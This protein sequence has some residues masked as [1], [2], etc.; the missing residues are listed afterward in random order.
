MLKILHQFQHRNQIYRITLP[1]IAVSLPKHGTVVRRVENNHLI[2]LN[3]LIDHHTTCYIRLETITFHR[4]ITQHHTT[5]QVENDGKI[6]K[7]FNT[8]V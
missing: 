6:L 2:K 3:E 1:G 8:A 7:C 4:T 5:N